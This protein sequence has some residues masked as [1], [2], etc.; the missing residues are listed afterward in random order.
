[1]FN[2]G[3][4]LSLL[5]DEIDLNE[6]IKATMSKTH[7]SLVKFCWNWFEFMSNCLGGNQWILIFAFSFQCVGEVG[8]TTFLM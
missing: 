8:G 4:Q 3:F 1:M 7:V 5:C 6:T 2:M